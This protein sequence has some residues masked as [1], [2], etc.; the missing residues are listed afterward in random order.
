MFTQVVAIL[1]ESIEKPK[2][3]GGSS[4]PSPWANLLCTGTLIQPDIVLTA[5]HCLHPEA[6]LADSPE[7]M[8]Q[9]SGGWLPVD[10][11]KVD[12]TLWV[13]QGPGTEGGRFDLQEAQSAGQVRT[14]THARLFPTL[15]VD[16]QGHGDLGLLKLDSPYPLTERTPWADT[17]PLESLV[18]P[19]P[20]TIVGF[21]RREDGGLGVKY[22]APVSFVRR[23]GYE[24]ILGGQGRDTCDG[25]SGGP[26]FL[27]PDG[28]SVNSLLLWGVSSRGTQLECGTGAYYQSV[29]QGRCWIQESLG[30]A[31]SFEDNPQAP[32]SADPT[33][34][35]CHQQLTEDLPPSKTLLDLCLTREPASSYATL[36]RL[37]ERYG[38]QTTQIDC[39]K[40]VAALLQLH[41]VSLEGLGISDIR[42]LRW[43]TGLKKISIKRNHVVKVA[44]LA[45]LGD[46]QTL[47]ITAN[48]IEDLPVFDAQW[49]HIHGTKSPPLVIGSHRQYQ[50]IWEDRFLK[51]C[52]DPAP[53]PALQKTLQGIMARTMA[54]SCTQAW[55]RMRMTENLILKKR[56]ITDLRPLADWAHLKSLDLSGNPDLTDLT[57]LQGLESLRVL[58]LTGTN[59]TDRSPLAGLVKNF[60]LKVID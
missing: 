27:T 16:L 35:Q 54:L 23:S 57:P 20:A 44:P 50:Q 37:A 33:T 46:L 38:P 1:V 25:D 5:G 31:Q 3:R 19:S 36:V 45:S 13:Y 47:D 14:V 39:P 22:Q 53:D 40:L 43:L 42:P 7:T 58:K 10:H 15:W 30:I 59:V 41:E 17:L 32:W 26:L 6:S 9:P 34:G 49:T 12:G 60:G 24:A 29:F 8:P 51:L 28:G 2:E 18:E 55:R 48:S 11:L 21:G 52:S 4:T 56:G